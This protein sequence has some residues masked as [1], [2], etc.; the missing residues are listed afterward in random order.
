VKRAWLLLALA[1]CPA[2][3]D[4]AV[5]PDDGAGP[6]RPPR[7]GPPCPAPVAAPAWLDG[8]LADHVARLAGAADIAPGVRLADRATASRRTT[9]RTYLADQ[10][11]GLGLTVSLDDYGQ[12]ANVVGEL[13]ATAAGA[14]EWIVVGAH[15]DTVTGSPGANDNA[16]G[17]AT[18]LAVARALAELPC[19]DRGVKVVLFD[20]EETGLIGSTTYA[21]RQFQAGTPIVAVHTIDQ[22]G[23]DADDD[24]RFELELPTPALLAEYQAGAAAVGAQVVSTTTSGTDHTAFRER[25]FAAIGLTEEYVSGDTTPHYHR[26]TDTAAT[27][28]RAYHVLATRLVTFV[29]ARELGAD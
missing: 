8:F 15:F 26:T 5:V 24:L 10:L 6:D 4:D 18:A 23:W 17:V 19:R 1:G 9:A 21:T 16:T 20:Q 2:G 13:P 22:V 28:D 11:T 3:D 29:V 25:G 27:V 7:D 12:G 14:T